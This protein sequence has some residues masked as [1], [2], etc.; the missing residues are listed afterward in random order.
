MMMPRE[1]RVD[2]RE[3]PGWTEYIRAKAMGAWPDSIGPIFGRIQW[4][5]SNSKGLID[6]VELP[7][8]MRDGVT[9]WEIMCQRGKLFEDVEWYHTKEEAEER[10]KE[11]LL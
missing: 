3:H 9:R 2:E 6:L 7:N 1:I 10:I 5:Y 4:L 8:Y 11:L